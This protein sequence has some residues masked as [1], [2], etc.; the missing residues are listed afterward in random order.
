ML[1]LK[2]VKFQ[3]ILCLACFA[4]FL[5]FRD[6]DALFLMAMAIAVISSL[7]AESVILYFRDKVLE[8]TE[9]SVITGLILGFVLS[10]D[11]AWWQIALS[12]VLAISSKYLIRFQ[13][14]HIFNPAAFGIFVILIIFNASTQWKGTY[15]WYILVPF[16]L[17][18]AYKFRRIEILVGYGIVFLVLF[19]LQ[20]VIQKIPFWGISGYL[21]LFYIFVMVIEPKTTPV[22]Q[23]AKFLFGALVSGLIFV[24]TNLGAGFD[25]ELLSLLVLNMA[26]PLLN[27]I[28]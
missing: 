27:R 26:V 19:G 5:S 12:S 16:G 8:F 1:A 22:K 6:K 20:A 10:S 17:Y 15:L 14:K 24:L 13:K 11:Q 28:S 9:S 25:V 2:S 7:C 18:F 3:L 4:L 23:K 21:S